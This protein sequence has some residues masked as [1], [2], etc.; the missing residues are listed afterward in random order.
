MPSIVQYLI[1]YL[2]GKKFEK[3]LRMTNLKNDLILAMKKY[4]EIMWRRYS[5][6]DIMQTV[7]FHFPH[8]TNA[9]YGNF[10]EKIASCD[11]PIAIAFGDRDYLCSRGCN[12]II[13]SSKHFSSGRSQLFKIK[14]SSHSV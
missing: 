10:D 7:P 12:E 6:S 13:R 2:I 5:V 1:F 9:S 8:M 4:K 3:K 11:F 14:D